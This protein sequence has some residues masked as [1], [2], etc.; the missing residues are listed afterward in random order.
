MEHIVTV[1][2]GRNIVHG[3]AKANNRS[4]EW[5]AWK[6]MKSRC[7]NPNDEKYKNYG[8]RGI[9]V[10]DEWKNS[11]QQFLCDMGIRPSIQH[12][13]ERDNVNGNYEP[14]N[15][16]WV[17][18]KE[19]YRNKTNTVH[20]IVNGKATYQS[21]FARMLKVDNKTIRTHLKSGKTPDEIVCYFNKKRINNN[22]QKVNSNGNKT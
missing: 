17:H 14:K 13:I 6:H 21:E 19:Q 5:E 1:C 16:R 7:Y 18:Y 9:I 12:S 4:P 2:K 20:L 22:N 15:C 8:A 11:F 10:C 3:H